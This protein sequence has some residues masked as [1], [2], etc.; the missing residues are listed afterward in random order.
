MHRVADL[1]TNFEQRYAGLVA[2]LMLALESTLTG[3]V[4]VQMQ[5]LPEQTTT[6]GEL[7]HPTKNTERQQ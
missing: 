4:E 2:L 1:R 6:T 3:M 5:I 7:Q